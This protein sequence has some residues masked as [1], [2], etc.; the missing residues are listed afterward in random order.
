MRGVLTG[1]VFALLLGAGAAR[2]QDTTPPELLVGT[3][4]SV[5]SETFVKLYFNEDLSTSHTLRTDAFDTSLGNVIEAVYDTGEGENNIVRLKF[6][7]TT[8]A[9][10]AVSI[11]VNASTVQ[12]T[13]GNLL[14]EARDFKLTNT[15]G[16]NAPKEGDDFKKPAL[17]DTAGAVVNGDTL[18]LTYDQRLL[19]RWPPTTAFTVNVTPTRTPAVTV[20]SLAIN[21]GASTSTTS[22]V[23]LTLSAAVKATD[24]VT[25]TYSTADEH[26]PGIQNE[27]GIQVNG[28]TNKAVDNNT[29]PVA[30]IRFKDNNTVTE[31]TSTPAKFTVTLSKAPAEDVTVNLTIMQDGNYVASG[32]LNDQEVTVTGGSM[33]AEHS[34]DIDDDSEDEPNGTVTATLKAGTGYTVGAPNSASVTVNDDDVPVASIASDRSAVTEGG[35]ARFTVTLDPVPATDL[36]VNLEITQVGDVV[37][38][39]DRGN[40]TVAV[41]TGGSTAQ[42]TVLTV[43]DSTHELNGGVVT[44]M[45]KAG[46]NY[47]VDAANDT[48]SITV[49]DN[50][51]AQTPQDMTPPRLVAG[52]IASNGGIYLYFSERLAWRNLAAS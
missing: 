49:N 19:P 44:A 15:H 35:R 30:S 12:D 32:D 22:T 23:V 2:A 3:F 13:A 29:P 47:T 26:Q 18:T 4:L 6:S 5:S 10:Q 11:T 45:L 37:A 51:P 46:D 20:S 39:G 34:V 48:A 36:T 52:S 25:L 1:V 17:S 9:T 8:T 40:K 14:K 41:A 28:L 33:S 24:A 43:N 21:P 38:S 7:T 42:H 27:W 31:G 50:D 16:D